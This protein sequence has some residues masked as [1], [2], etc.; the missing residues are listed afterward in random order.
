MNTKENTLNK[1]I[2]TVVANCITIGI[3]LFVVNNTTFEIKR[4]SYFNGKTNISYHFK[5]F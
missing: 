5:F 3:L 1:I 4:N 2:S